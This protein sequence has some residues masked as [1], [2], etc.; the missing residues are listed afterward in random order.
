MKIATLATVVVMAVGLVFSGTRVSLGAQNQVA[1]AAAPPPGR[2]N[3]SYAEAKPILDVLRADL[4][5]AE[6]RTQ[7]P[8]QLESTWP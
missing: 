1:P 3:M 2:A 6:L 7:S 8:A 5:P 4:L